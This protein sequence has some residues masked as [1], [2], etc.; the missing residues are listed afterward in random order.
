MKVVLSEFSVLP[1]EVLVAYRPRPAVLPEGLV[2]LFFGVLHVG[3]QWGLRASEAS[4]M[5][6]SLPAKVSR[7]PIPRISVN[8]P[9]GARA[10]RTAISGY[11]ANRRA[12]AKGG[13]AHVDRGEQ[14]HRSPVLLR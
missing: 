14:G 7:S 9:R 10:R 8:K 3:G 2:G 12:M 5:P 11:H 13:Y 4:A 6:V 1:H